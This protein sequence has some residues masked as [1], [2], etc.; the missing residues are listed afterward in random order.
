M[1][2]TVILR[3]SSVFDECVEAKTFLPNRFGIWI[4]GGPEFAGDGKETFQL[5]ILV[6]DIDDHDL[7]FFN[8]ICDETLEHQTLEQID[9]VIDEVKKWP[10]I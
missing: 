6:G 1:R 4:A 5:W 2:N 10:I 3:E 7:L 9:E 8:S